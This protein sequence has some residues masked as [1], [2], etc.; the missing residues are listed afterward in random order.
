MADLPGGRLAFRQRPFTHTGV[1]YF[2]PLEVTVGRRREKRWAALFTCLTTRAVHMEVA[3]SLSAD[4][5]IMAL[6]R[7]MARR[8]Q[9]DTLYSDHGTNFVGAAAELSSSPGDRRANVRR[10]DDSGDTMAAH[11]R[12]AYG[13]WSQVHKAA[14]R[15]QPGHFD[16][17]EE[18]SRKQWRASQALAEMF[19]Q[20]WLREYLPTLQRRHKWTEATDQSRRRG[21]HHRPALPRNTWPRGIVERVYPGIDGQ[22]RVVDIRTAHGRLRR[23][24][25]RLAVLP[26]EV[27]SSHAP[28]GGGL[29]T[30]ELR[31]PCAAVAAGEGCAGVGP[32]IGRAVRDARAHGKAA[33]LG[34]QRCY[35]RARRHQS[36]FNRRRGNTLSTPSSETKFW[37]ALRPPLVSQCKRG[38]FRSSAR[39]QRLN[40]KRLI[41]QTIEEAPLSASLLLAVFGVYMLELFVFDVTTS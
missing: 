38:N 9:P 3:S 12:P 20:R 37:S 23:P 30:A 28:T 4:S 18:C 7:F 32:L 17:S 11:T 8:G 22:V 41:R 10:G 36:A 25:A 19:W 6:R 34:A 24:T 1:D 35:M 26:T 29:L 21:R 15:W 33:A 40:N 13:R 16:T 5:M 27:E 2:G 39:A 31:P 14:G